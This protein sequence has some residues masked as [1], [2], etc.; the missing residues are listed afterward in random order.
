M[1]RTEWTSTPARRFRETL[2]LFQVGV[3][4]M[5]QNI[6]RSAPGLDDEAIDDRLRHWLWRYP[7]QVPRDHALR[8][9]SSSRPR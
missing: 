8:L 5:R 3:S 1:D 7:A 9:V 2:D 4:L 6:H